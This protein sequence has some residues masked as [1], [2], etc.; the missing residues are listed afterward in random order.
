MFTVYSKPA[1]PF[2]DQAK[3]LLTQK[4]LPFQVIMLDVGQPKV[5]GQQYIQRADLL[6][7]FPYARTVPQIIDEREHIGGFAELRKW[8]DVDA[9]LREQVHMSA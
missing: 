2:C 7:L 4:G 3:A 8:L 1:C 6:A 5:E 9:S